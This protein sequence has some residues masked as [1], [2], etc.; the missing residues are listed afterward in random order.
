MVLNENWKI[1]RRTVI[2]SWNEFVYNSRR[3]LSICS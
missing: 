3:T 2:R 1:N